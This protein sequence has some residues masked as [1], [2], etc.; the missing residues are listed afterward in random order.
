[1]L[2]L[3][4]VLVLLLGGVLTAGWLVWKRPLRVFT[5]AARRSLR[6]L[7]LKQLT[8]PSPV[9][10]Q[11]VFVGG[12]GPVLVLLHG[13]GDQAGTWAR[14][15]GALV[16][17]HTLVIPDLPGHGDSAPATGP[18]ETSA[19]VAGLEVVLASQAQGRPLTLVG[20][21]LGGWMAMVLARRHPDWVDLVVAVNG[22]AMKGFGGNVNLLPR[23]REEAR[24]T[25]AQLRD[26]G[27]PVVPDHVLDDMT[28]RGVTSPLARFAATAATME[29]WLLEEAD[30]RTLQVPVR[31]VWGIADQLMPLDYARRL[32]AA[33]P[34][35]RLIPIEHCGHIP[36][37]EAPGRF[38]EALERALATP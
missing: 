38:L 28:R 11:S 9:G 7:P 35:A 13:A 12:T 3:T 1:M 31:L 16:K 24:R 29:A 19:L 20:N 32:E 34:D 36:Q 4:M 27:N 22:G 21:S 25:M 33:L 5:W 8:I 30:L 17:K 6:S 15:A 10:P 23:T 26:P 14:V 18:I 37:Q 2:A